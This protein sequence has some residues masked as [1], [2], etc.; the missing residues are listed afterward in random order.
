MSA[1]KSSKSPPAQGKR[2]VPERKRGPVGLHPSQVSGLCKDDPTFEEFCD[3]LRQPRA[4]DYRQAQADTRT[5]IRQEE[6]PER[7]SSSTPTP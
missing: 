7:C 4:E 3:I 2:K 1:R 5:M 6:E